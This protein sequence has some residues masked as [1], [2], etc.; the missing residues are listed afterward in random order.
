MENIIIY[1]ISKHEEFRIGLKRLLEITIPSVEIK[2]CNKVPEESVSESSIVITEPLF[3]N[4]DR[5]YIEK[6]KRFTLEN[7]IKVCVIL[8]NSSDE[9]VLEL[10]NYQIHGVLF[11]SMPT[12]ELI[13]GI[14]QVIEGGYY[15]PSNVGKI[16]LDAYQQ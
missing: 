12:D 14:K 15:I 3:E 6:W 16:L 10:L 5:Q 13:R 1:I 8:E 7:R 4:N 9:Q 2:T 11:K